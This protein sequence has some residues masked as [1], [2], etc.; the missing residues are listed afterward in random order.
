V[1]AKIDLW[2]DLYV[3]PLS[4]LCILWVHN[5]SPLYVHNSP[6]IFLNIYFLYDFWW[7]QTC[8]FRAISD[9][10]C[11]I[12]QYYSCK[13]R[14]LSTF[15]AH[16]YCKW[17]FI[18]ISAIYMKWCTQTLPPCSGLF[19]I[20]DRNFAKLVALPGDESKQS[21]VSLKRQSLP[22]RS[23]RNSIKSTHKPWLKPCSIEQCRQTSSVTDKHHT[24]APITAG[25]RC[26]ISPN[27]ARWWRTSSPFWKMSIIIRSNL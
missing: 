11:E 19:A 18:K 3:C 10:P 24:L 15:S 25:T 5:C 1:H 12:W 14:S 17:N 27:Y 8:S 23:G 16:K 22:K 20:F 2:C 9:Y 13:S 4:A 26:S 7:A 21:Q 6:K